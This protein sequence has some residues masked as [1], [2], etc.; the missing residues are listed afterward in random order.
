MLSRRRVRAAWGSSTAPQFRL[1]AVHNA[2]NVRI[3]IT[4]SSWSAPC[5]RCGNPVPSGPLRLSVR[6]MPRPDRAARSERL[7][8]FPHASPIRTTP[9]TCCPAPPATVR[10]ATC[11]A[12]VAPATFPCPTSPPP[13]LC[14]L[15]PAARPAAALPSPARFSRSALP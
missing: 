14:S 5:P 12:S 9:P 3:H 15:K 10:V 7:T 6:E 11:T 13:L 8:K 1:F 4:C 2:V